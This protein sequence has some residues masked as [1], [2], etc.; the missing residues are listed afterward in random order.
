MTVSTKRPTITVEVELKDAWGAKQA[1]EKAPAIVEAIE[2][3]SRVV[4]KTV[5]VKGV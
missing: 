2:K 3:D 1:L 4:V 5:R